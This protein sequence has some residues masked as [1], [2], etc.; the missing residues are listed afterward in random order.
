MLKLLHGI[1]TLW[2]S[3]T[4]FIMT[5]L[6]LFCFLMIKLFIPY[7]KQIQFV[8]YV[9]RFF[10]FFWSAINGIRYKITGLENINKDQTYICVLNHTNSGDMVAGAYGCRVNAKPLIKRELT[11]IPFLGQ[12]LSIACIAVDRSSKEAR[13]KSK[14]NMLNDLKQKI[15]VLIFAEGTRN[16]TGKPLKDFFDGAFDLAIDAQVPIIPIV[17]TNIKKINPKHDWFFRPT[18][19]EVRHLAPIF[20]DGNSEASIQK[21]KANTFKNMWNCLVEFDDEFKKYDKL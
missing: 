7:P 19:I 11:L 12:M 6:M 2:L 13:K 21:L 18:T 8:Y 4:F 9:N 16:R 5:P 10:F 1:Y 3:L 20:P 15:S 14:E 17:L